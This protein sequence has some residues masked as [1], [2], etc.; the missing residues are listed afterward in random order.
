MKSDGVV[1]LTVC[2]SIVLA[3]CGMSRT[4]D[5]PTVTAMPMAQEVAGITPI[6][7]TE[8]VTPASAENPGSCAYIWATQPLPTE[9]AKIQELFYQAGMTDYQVKAEAFGENCVA[10]DGSIVSFGASETI[11]TSPS[12]YWTCKIAMTLVSAF[13]H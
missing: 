2:L 3:A 6:V 4:G 13:M 5:F 11:F 10:E 8:T 7:I 9:S 12:P 1:G